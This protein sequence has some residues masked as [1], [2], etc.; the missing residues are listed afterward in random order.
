MAVLGAAAAGAQ[1]EPKPANPAHPTQKAKPADV[2][3]VPLA[4]RVNGRRSE[5]GVVSA[6][7]LPGESLT[8]EAVD[9]PG[10][11]GYQA[12][13]RP[14]LVRSG[15][16]RWRWTART[17]G[18]LHEIELRDEDRDR[19]VIV[20]AFVLFPIANVKGG[21]LKGY[22]IGAYPKGPPP[23]RGFIEV[24]DDNEDAHL[25]PHF[26]LKQFVCKQKADYPKYV[27]LDERLLLKLEDVL[28][29]VNAAGHPGKTLHV[30]SG[31]RTPFYNALID[32]VNL[33]QHQW[34][35][36]ADVFV[37]ENGDGMMDDLNR[38]GTLDKDDARAFFAI[39]DGMDRRPGAAFPGGLGLYGATMAHGPFVHVDVRGRLARW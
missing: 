29:A 24:T 1:P 31:Y 32:N 27:A 33:S 34:G 25:T 13:G 37:D 11:R 21:R 23:P 14:A 16:R 8:L 10:P 17:P 30:M 36:A 26:Q 12:E 35:S 22:R 6:F 19:R 38:D 28:A 5:H 20:H 7:L 4:V 39:V 18:D 2:S 9:P 15:P 3:D